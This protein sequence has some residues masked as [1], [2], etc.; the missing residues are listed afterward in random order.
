[1]LKTIVTQWLLIGIYLTECSYPPLLAKEPL[2]PC[3]L[4]PSH[5]AHEYI[6]DESHRPEN[7]YKNIGDLPSS[8]DWRWHQNQSYT[9]RVKNSLIQQYC[10]SC[11][12]LVHPTVSSTKPNT[13][14]HTQKK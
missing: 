3:L 6:S 9:S 4:P 1:M 10:A 8:L 2:P 5:D 12:Y 11:W 7:K 13:T 14:Q